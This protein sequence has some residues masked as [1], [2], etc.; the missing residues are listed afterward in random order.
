M[1]EDRITRKMWEDMEL[2]NKTVG[3]RKICQIRHGTGMKSDTE[4]I[5]I[6]C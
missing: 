5:K 2:K 4:F 1:E 3:P 6:N